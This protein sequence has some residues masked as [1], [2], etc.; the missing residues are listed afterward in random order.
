MGVIRYALWLA[1]RLAG[2]LRWPPP[3]TLASPPADVPSGIRRDVITLALADG[4]TQAS[5]VTPLENTQGIVILLHG[6]GLGRDATWPWTQALLA[7]GLATLAPDLDG[8]GNNSRLYTS[9][10][11]AAKVVP[12]ALAALEGHPASG[13]VGLLGA[14]LGGVV[15]LHAVAQPFK[16]DQVGAVAL[17]ATPYTS[18]GSQLLSPYML[19]AI[20][21]GQFMP[22]V[23]VS[24]AVP[25]TRADLWRDILKEDRLL[26]CVRTASDVPL[27][28]VH[29]AADPFAPPGQGRAFQQ[30]HGNAT[31]W[32]VPG[33]HTTAMYE[34]ALLVRVAG[35][36]RARL[37]SA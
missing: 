14:S 22:T 4:N 17:L 35:W 19:R 33:S 34:P 16:R 11:V 20:W 28:L 15:A 7:Q 24:R 37:N 5:L 25:R 13:K 36:M 9:A 3:I 29:G 27:L 10:R 8:H 31:L 18:P 30:A 26:D 32:A 21:E 6:G 23:P 12:A 2:P 1:Q